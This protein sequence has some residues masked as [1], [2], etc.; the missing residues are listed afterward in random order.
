MHMVHFELEAVW[1]P[2]SVLTNIDS[3]TGNLL[4]TPLCF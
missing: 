3:I 4:L 1:P 2:H